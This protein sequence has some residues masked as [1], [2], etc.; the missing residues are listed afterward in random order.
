MVTQR[1]CVERWDE[2]IVLWISMRY[3]VSMGIVILLTC[4]Q[5]MA[6]ILKDLMGN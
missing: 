4:D 2:V 5:F 6:S 3:R 1:E